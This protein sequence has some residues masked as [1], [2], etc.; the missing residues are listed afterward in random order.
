[1]AEKTPDKTDEKKP[2]AATKAAKQQAKQFAGHD[3][4]YV[5]LAEVDIDGT[6][7]VLTCPHPG[8][9]NIE[10]PGVVLRPAPESYLED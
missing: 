10:S 1:M 6:P 7:Y 9:H 5:V 8:K 3:F 4:V 2:T